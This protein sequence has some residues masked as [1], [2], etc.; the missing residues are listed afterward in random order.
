L[1]YCTS[2]KYLKAILAPLFHE[3]S[4]H[5]GVGKQRGARSVR[6]V[7]V[8]RAPA[9]CSTALASDWMHRLG[10]AGPAA[11]GKT[12]GQQQQTKKSPEALQQPVLAEAR[13]LIVT[14]HPWCRA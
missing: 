11:Q 14:A 2:K 12:P 5:A 7:T 3:R 6:T 13:G 1:V 10:K 4:A 9:L 8:R